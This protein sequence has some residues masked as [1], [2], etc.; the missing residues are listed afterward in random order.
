MT[1]RKFYRT[2]IQVEVLSEEPYDFGGNL[3]QLGEDITTGDCS[4]VARTIQ[5]EECDGARM[6]RLL[7]AQ[8]SDPSFFMLDE[9]GEDK[10][11]RAHV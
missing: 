9:T 3:R 8:G 1:K 2:V 4:G 7:V 6:T 11:G 5:T 10:I